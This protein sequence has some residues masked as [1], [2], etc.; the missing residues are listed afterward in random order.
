MNRILSPLERTLFSILF[1]TYCTWVC[2]PDGEFSPYVSPDGEYSFF[3]STRLMPDERIPVSLTADLLHQY[4]MG[5]ESGNTG[6]VRS[7]T[8]P[9]RRN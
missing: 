5:A 4:R 1:L 3:M 7:P 9:S 2:G 6:R 8:H